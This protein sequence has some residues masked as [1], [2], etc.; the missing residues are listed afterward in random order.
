MRSSAA[1][2][3][4][5]NGRKLSTHCPCSGL[6]SDATLRWLR[7]VRSPAVTESLAWPGHRPT[8]S[9]KAWPTTWKW[10][11]PSS[12]PWNVPGSS[13][14]T[15]INHWLRGSSEDHL[16]RVLS[17][18]LLKPR[19]EG[20]LRV[21]S[22]DRPWVC[23]ERPPKVP[24]VGPLR[25]PSVGL[26]RTPSVGLLRTPSVG[27]LRTPSVGLLRT[28]SVGLLRTPS[29]DRPWVHG[30]RERPRRAPSEGRARVPKET[31]RLGRPARNS[32][33]HGIPMRRPARSRSRHGIP[34]ARSR[35]DDMRIAD[36][37]VIDVRGSLTAQRERLLDFLAGLDDGAWGSS[38]V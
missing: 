1:R 28:P 6:V 13:P 17:R 12:R 5:G 23:G 8:W 27:L 21:P 14:P 31:V 33:R 4:S 34:M 15:S 16:P 38:A 25:T 20:P 22:S 24:R 2:H 3:P 35:G 26:L 7:P 30:E 19:R 29:V 11:P 32:L 18:R 10:T 36:V 37:P 9:T